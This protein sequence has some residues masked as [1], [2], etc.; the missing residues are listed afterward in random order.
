MP[1]VTQQGPSTGSV[2]MSYEYGLDVNTGT[3]ASPI[4]S[5]IPDI[6]GLNP[7]MSDQTADGTTYANK[8]QTDNT[9]IGRDF[10]PEF[11]AKPVADNQGLMQPALEKLVAAAEQNGTG[12]VVGIRLY[13]FRFKSLAWSGHVGVGYS[14]AN[15]GNAD[16]ELLAFTTT[17]KGD[18]EQIDNPAFTTGS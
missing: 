11:S 10:A 2:G 17:S 15:T 1:Q 13:S 7:N 9:K 3:E 16:A 8:G 18:F 12:N 5:N 6:T 4:W 14:R